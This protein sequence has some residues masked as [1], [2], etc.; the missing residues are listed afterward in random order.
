VTDSFVFSFVRFLPVE[1]LGAGR[2][3]VTD[4]YVGRGDAVVARP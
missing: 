2:Q 3:A 1:A 4:P